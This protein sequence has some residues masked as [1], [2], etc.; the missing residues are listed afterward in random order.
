MKK[1]LFISI[2]LLIVSK[3]YSYDLSG[4]WMINRWYMPQEN[5]SSQEFSWG[6][7]YLQPYNWELII[8]EESNIVEMCGIGSFDIKEILKLSESEYILKLFFNRGNFDVEY[9]IILM[10]EKEFI[11][12]NL[13]QDTQFISD[14]EEFHYYRI[15]GPKN[16]EYFSNP[17][18]AI[19]LGESNS[20]ISLKKGEQV[21]LIGNNFYSKRKNDPLKYWCM[22]NSNDYTYINVDS[23]KIIDIDLGLFMKVNENLQLRKTDSLSSEIITTIITG[24]KVKVLKLGK[25]S[26]IDEDN[27]RWIQIE[28]LSSEIDVNKKGYIGWCLSNYLE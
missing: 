24:T 18:N 21:R 17:I 8:D 13:T 23:I 25:G 2:F 14:G 1:N 19:Y 15:S 12:E 16:V 20:N 27:N 11:L 3:I 26:D 28:I 22:N 4:I 9:K 10:N 7:E 5:L 6:V